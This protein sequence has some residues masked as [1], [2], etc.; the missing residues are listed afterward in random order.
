LQ[1]VCLGQ[2]R[3]GSGAIESG[4][5]PSRRSEIFNLPYR[6]FIIGWASD[7]AECVMHV[8]G[9]Q[10]AILRYGRLQIC[11]TPDRRFQSHPVGLANV[12]WPFEIL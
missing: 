6:R 7:M 1:S 9:P 3:V 12:L 2:E 5:Q 8:V 4:G 10:N 11:A